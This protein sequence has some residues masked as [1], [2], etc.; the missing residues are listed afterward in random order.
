MANIAQK[1]NTW[2]LAYLP[3]VWTLGNLGSADR[4][5]L[6]V[7]INGQEIATFKQPQ[8]PAGVAHFDISRVLQSY[9][10][11]AYVENTFQLAETPGAAL[12]YQV[13]FGSETNGNVLIDGTEPEQYV[14]N[15]YDNWRVL[16]WDYVDYIPYANVDIRCEFFQTN[17]LFTRTYEYLTNWPTTDADGL[18]L[19]KVRSDEYRTLSFFNRY[20][21][22]NDGTLWGP[23]EGPFFVEYA[24]YT[25]NGALLAKDIITI[26]SLSG[27]PVR[28]DCADLNSHAYTDPQ[29][30]A[31]V[32]VG[33]QN[34]K[35]SSTYWTNAAK[36][37]TVKVYSYNNC[38]SIDPISDCGDTSLLEEYKGDLIYGARFEINDACSP[39]EPINVS[40]MNRFGVKDYYTFDR[41]NTY[42]TAIERST[43]SKMLGSWSQSDFNIDPTGRGRTAFNTNGTTVMQLSTN[44]MTDAESQ[45]LEEL[46]MSP[47]VMIYLNGVWEPVVVTSNAY[48]Q[49][50][51]S[52]DKMFQHTIEVQFANDKQS[53]RG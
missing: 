29:I 12:S 20:Y 53:Q 27:M 41:R 21:N 17:A 36:T 52:R 18:K 1:P 50:S 5:V 23:N 2:N 10:G 9:L 42:T 30:I 37:Y 22:F 13:K 49:K 11:T 35:D 7:V 28:T 3:N 32:G 51:Y 39:F 16:N 34:I 6:I 44:W 47:S 40:F 26:D 45:W 33:P 48:E 43:Y 8:N 25:A 38:W 19:F 14:L 4:F 31:T 24:Y 46:Y 15:G